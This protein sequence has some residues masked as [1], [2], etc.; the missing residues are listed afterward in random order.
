MA[1]QL[2]ALTTVSVHLPLF[3]INFSF[4]RDT[5]HFR[6]SA[7]LLLLFIAVA[8]ALPV[9]RVVVS[10]CACRPPRPSRPRSDSPALF[11]QLR[12]LRAR[13]ARTG[14]GRSGRPRPT[15]A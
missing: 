13:R 9:A 8:Y 3:F 7:I 10:R 6:A 4:A 14:G 15:R 2:A 12:T 5:M 1:A 11:S